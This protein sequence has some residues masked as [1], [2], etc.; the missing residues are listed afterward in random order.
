MLSEMFLVFQKKLICKETVNSQKIQY[1][2]LYH[3]KV[4]YQN[5]CIII[6]NDSFILEL[7]ISISIRSALLF[8]G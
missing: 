7:S 5:F 1:K 2:E 3:K 4:S 8:W 6:V